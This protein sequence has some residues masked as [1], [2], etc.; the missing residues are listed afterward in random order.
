MRIR[1]VAAAVGLFFVTACS[2]GT[3]TSTETTADDATTSSEATTTQA[4]PETEE[5]ETTVVEDTEP[6]ESKAPTL[7]D[8]TWTLVSG[9]RGDLTIDLVDGNPVT[10]AFAEDGTITG[11][12]GCGPYETTYAIDSDQ[13]IIEP[14]QMPE[15][16]DCEVPNIKVDRVYS[17]ALWESKEVALNDTELVLTGQTSELLYTS[18]ATAAGD[19]T[20]DTDGDT[21]SGVETGEALDFILGSIGAEPTDEIV[22]CFEGVGADPMMGFDGSEE[23]G[24]AFGLALATCVPDELADVAAASYPPSPDATPEDVK[25]I[26]LQVYGR[27]SELSLS[28]ATSGPAYLPPE[29][30]AEALSRAQDTCGVTEEVAAEVIEFMS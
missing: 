14:V 15:Q 5:D 7:T 1:N 22:S 11:Q 26:A 12:A 13:I 19:G 9:S 16:T 27:V 29:A 10:L 24:A 30:R 4:P 3:D 25:C 8:T 23:E 20:S 6:D 18:D 17:I 28:E 2:S 21:A